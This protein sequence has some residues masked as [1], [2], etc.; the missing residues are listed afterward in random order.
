MPLPRAAYLLIAAA[1]F[2]AVA[3]GFWLEI[4]WIVNFSVILILIG[5]VALLRAFG[6]KTF[7]RRSRGVSGGIDESRPGG[8]APT[9]PPPAW[10]S[11]LRGVGYYFVGCFLA[12][13]VMIASMYALAGGG[14]IYP[15]WVT[16]ALIGTAG[17]L[18][19]GLAARGGVRLGAI[20]GLSG[21]LVILAVFA[22]DL[23]GDPGWPVILSGIVFASSSGLAG[24]SGGLIRQ[25][26]PSQLRRIV[27]VIEDWN[28]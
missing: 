6:V 24:A 11:V 25:R 26:Y 23:S 16:A 17:G 27:E 2:A 9:P 19:A 21:C 15:D 3:V 22:A 12:G 28:D 7:E 10:R 1:A 4:L 18:G 14:N 20:A 13:A 5:F 8:P